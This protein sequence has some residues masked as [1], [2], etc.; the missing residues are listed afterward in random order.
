MSAN[1]IASN[2]HIKILDMLR[3]E[4][5]IRVDELSEYFEVSP[6]TIRR[7]L[8]YL[9]SQRLLSR[10][11]GGAVSVDTEI[12]LMVPERNFNEKGVINRQEKHRIAEMAASLVEDDEILFV[13]SGSTALMLIEA[14]NRKKL[15]IV[16]NNA[17][18]ITA[19]YNPDMELIVLGGEY[20]AQ[21][22]SL[23]GILTLE[24]IQ[25]INSTHTFLGVN[26]FSIDKGLTTSVIQEC[27]V[28]QAMIRN[29]NGKVVVLADHAKIGRVSNFVSAPLD[30]V[31]I[32]VT[33]SKT[34]KEL[35][36]QIEALGIEVLL[37]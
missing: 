17:G 32:L 25:G 35:I 33:D 4:G 11:H 5:K 7:D 10:T 37:A 20:R 26:G 2:R 30:V 6:V 9:N 23:V 16:T 34:P 1:T 15:K 19:P 31:D 14:V 8:D 21:S 3:E 27:S 22:Q 28:N 24:N 29:T 18:A 13:N 12:P 36:A